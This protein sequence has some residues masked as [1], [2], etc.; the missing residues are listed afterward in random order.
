MKRTTV[1][2]TG[3]TGFA[4]SHALQALATR[5]DVRLIAHC[6]NPARLPAGYKGEVRT[7]D[8]CDPTA[9]P[10]LLEGVD[11]ITSYNVCYT[12]LLRRCIA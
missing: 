3:A 12:K 1:L 7:A 8:L 4:G 11:R 6:R 10:A 5:E 9:L 2:V